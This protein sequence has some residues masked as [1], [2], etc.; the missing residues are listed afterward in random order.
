[1][2]YRMSKLLLAV[3][4]AGLTCA[5]LAAHDISGNWEFN[6]D[7]AAGSGSPS[8]VFTQ[9]GEKLTGT[10]SGLFGKADLT[11]TVKGDQIDF[12]FNFNYSGQSGVCHYTGT[13]ESDA[14]MKGKVTIGD[15]GDG[16]WTATKQK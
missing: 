3:I 14:K 12:Q 1:M 16:E 8:F 11:G 6:V 4:L 13:I 7:T 2:L 15:L 10:Y 5:S 9:D